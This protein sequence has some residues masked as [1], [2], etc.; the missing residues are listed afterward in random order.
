MDEQP[1]RL[2]VGLQVEPGYE[3]VAEQKGKDVIA[4]LALV[5][6][7][8]NLDPVV[9]VEEPHARERSQT[10][11]SNGASSARAEMRRGLRASR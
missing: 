3:L 7:R 8:V 1:S 6:R 11:G 4:V 2:A 9:E 10:S 5:R